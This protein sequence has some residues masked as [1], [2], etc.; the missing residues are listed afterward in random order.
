MARPKSFNKEHVLSLALMVFW[1]QGY[2]AT[3][4]KDLEVATQLTPG[5]IYHEFGSKLGMFENV[6]NHYIDTVMAFRVA[7]YLAQKENPLQSV[8]DFLVSSFENV[9]QEVRG[10]ACLLVNTATE[11]GKTKPEV[12]AVIKRGYKIIE[13]GLYKQ[14]Q[15]A[16][17]KGNVREDLD[18]QAAA[19]QLTYLMSG[20]LVVSKN[21]NNIDSLISTVDFTL[22]AYQ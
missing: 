13:T 4:M 20:L 22:L 17:A 14:L 10:D 7:H 16:Q 5:S 18:C 9:P 2:D 12:S 1:K 11:L 19:R 6:L 21:Q 8:R 15:F 3:S